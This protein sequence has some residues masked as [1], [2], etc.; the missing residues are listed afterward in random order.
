MSNGEIQDSLRT[1]WVEVLEL[2]DDSGLPNFFDAG[3]DSLSAIELMEK[4]EE[5]LEIEF[6][7]EALFASGDFAV[8]LEECTSRY[9]SVGRP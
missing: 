9:H 4:V 8:V 1:S 3:G 5:A 7:L 2:L 6:P